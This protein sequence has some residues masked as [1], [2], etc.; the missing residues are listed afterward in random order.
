MSAGRPPKPTALKLVDGDKNKERINEN[1]P[2][3][4]TTMPPVPS[5]LD[6]M[7]K[8]HW[9]DMA[10][11]LNSLGLLTSI[12]RDMFA[13]YCTAYSNWRKAEAVVRD[14]GMTF[15]TD[16]G[17]IKRRPETT[18]AK[19]QMTIWKA[20]ASEFGMTPSSR[21]KIQVSGEDINEAESF[22]FG[23]K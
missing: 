3:P 5:Y 22:L 4:D 12:D 2:K 9:R 8:R 19:E 15:T 1:E 11:V 14:E 17:E 16:K 18:I 23:T 13:A 10:E 7:A 6:A 20:L 21:T